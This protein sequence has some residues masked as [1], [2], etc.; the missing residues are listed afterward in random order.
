MPYKYRTNLFIKA[1]FVLFLC[2]SI[3]VYAQETGEPANE[4]EKTELI[5]TG[6]GTNKIPVTDSIRQRFEEARAAVKKA[7][8]PTFNTDT[9]T[10]FRPTSIKYS[11][12]SLSAEVEYEASDS[13]LYDVAGE[14]IYLFGNASLVYE[15]MT[16]KADRIIFDWANDI[17]VAYGYEDSLGNYVGR[18]EFIDGEQQFNSDT[19]RYNYRTNK[20]KVYNVRT[21]EGDGYLLS[22][23]VKFDLRSQKDADHEDIAFAK[24]T[25]YTTCN[26]EDPHFG[27]RSSRAKII[28]NKLIVVGGSNVEIEH[29]PTP[30]WLPFGFFPLKQGQRSGLIFPRNYEF[31]PTLG[32]GLRNI[33]YYK[34]L[35]DYLDL[36]VTGDIYT[37]GSWGLSA[38][39][40]YTKRYKYNGGFGL[41][42]SYRKLDIKGVPGY[43]RE[44]DFNIRWNHSQAAS[45]HPTRTFSASLNLGTGSFFTNNYNDAQSVLT[46]T[47]SSNVSLS[48]RF[49]GKPYSLSTSF[50]HSQNTNTRDMTINFPQVDFRVSQINPFE[51]KN[52]IGKDRWYE[53]INMRYTARAENRIQTKDTLL[54]TREVFDDMEY[55]VRHD[56]PVSASFNLAKYFTVTPNVRYSEKWYF[57]T[58][59]RTFDAENVIETD[60]IFEITAEGDTLINSIS[61]DTTDFGQII[62]GDKFGFRS[63]REVSGG[64]SINTTLY[65]MLPL[66]KKGQAIRH[67]MR[68][69]VSMN[70]SPDYEREFWKYYE[71]VQVD[72]RYPDSVAIYSPFDGGLYGTVPRGGRQSSMSFSIA[73]TLEGK[74]RTRRDTAQE[75]KKVKL[76][77]SFNVSSAYNFAADS[78]NLS[79]I[80]ANGNT[81]L[82]KVVD[83]RFGANFDPYSRDNDGRTVDIY[84]WKANKRLARFTGG[85]V[86]LSTRLNPRDIEEAFKKDKTES[87]NKPNTNRGKQFIGSLTFSYSFRVSNAFENGKDTIKITTNNLNLSRTKFNLTDKLS[88]D[89]GNIGYDFV[90][91]RVSYPDLSFYRDLHCWE[92]GFSWQPE[93]RTYS[94]FLR[95]KPSS[96]DFLKI[97]YSRNRADPFV[98]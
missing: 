83:L 59:A 91:K 12:D 19:I 41:S 36:Q 51:R 75:L 58:L 18:P 84:E 67:V 35:N 63:L 17:A 96:L 87:D 4:S 14:R 82:F 48:K 68:P 45:A 21:E 98:F 7:N 44:Q 11:S 77:N 90:R 37:R 43:G 62:D 42:F 57:N 25:L 1:L 81:K 34:A 97:P 13:M 28:P 9:T 79:Q 24:G 65:G 10:A 73:N 76:L 52:K 16:L 49:P 89:V 31:S 95:V 38:S 85:F 22:S 15:D 60:T 23:S 3:G 2:S 72:N 93:R 20:G 64:V 74:F 40:N 69:S 66:G 27:I 29:V 61:M 33:G 30:L 56:L 71:E 55:G 80:S 53:K 39:S 88:M 54:F 50:S 92:T 26:A 86:N 70:F 46:N 32:F 6:K 5:G 94:F 8:N 47:L 78:L